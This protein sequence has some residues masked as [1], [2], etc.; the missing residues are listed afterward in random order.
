MIK[1]SHPSFWRCVVL[2]LMLALP[3][4]SWAARN[5]TVTPITSGTLDN[6]SAK[7]TLTVDPADTGKS[8]GVYVA[9]WVAGSWCFLDA[10]GAWQT[11]NGGVL[12]VY[13]QGTL[14]SHTVSLLAGADA[15]PLSG[16]AFYLAYGFD[17]ADMTANSIFKK[18]LVVGATDT[19]TLEG[20]IYIKGTTTPLQGALVSTS[21]DGQTAVTDAS[22]HFLLKTGVAASGSTTPY[23]L[24][25]S[26]SGYLALSLANTV[27]D[28]LSGQV[29]YLAPS[30]A[31]ATNVLQG[32][33]KPASGS[34][35]AQSPGQTLAFVGSNLVAG[36]DGPCTYVGSYQI[37]G[38]Q[39]TMSILL[40]V[41]DIASCPGAQQGSVRVGTFKVSGTQL[42]ITSAAGSTFVFDKASPTNTTSGTWKR[43]YTTD[44]QTAQ[45]A[46]SFVMDNA[47][48]VTETSGQ[49]VKNMFVT[50]APLA[51]NPLMLNW[52]TVWKGDNGLCTT[53]IPVGQ[54]ESGF[55]LV[56]GDLLY[57]WSDRGG[58]RVFRR[59]A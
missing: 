49:C 40:N 39:L 32:M 57:L 18:A 34:S 27:G 14:G 54:Q 17:E 56:L 28:H 58:V 9:A 46:V 13:Q 43:I 53:I 42:M 22:G 37:S 29:Y 52:N 2:L 59:A 55:A 6:Y 10:T 44:S 11:W 21:L 45:L 31:S 50:S 51:A 16:T 26:A 25:I 7:A 33:W 35:T 47:G 12:P 30:T 24:K 3:A 38:D 19:V 20:T 5:F 8:G 41:P 15:R 36:T 4:A 48:N 1:Q 23:T